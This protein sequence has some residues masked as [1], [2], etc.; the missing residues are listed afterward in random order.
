MN[1]IVIGAVVVGL[2]V[3]AVIVRVLHR[4]GPGNDSSG[5]PVFGDSGWSSP[6]T[7]FS[8]GGNGGGGSQDCGGDSGTVGSDCGGGGDGGGGGGG[9][10]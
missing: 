1:I 6:A 7:D 4:A 9:G 2:A 5:S 8:D 10:E 3:V